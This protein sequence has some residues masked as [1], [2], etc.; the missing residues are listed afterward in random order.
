M[1][2]AAW[3][4]VLLAF[5]GCES[6][7]EAREGNARW[8]DVDAQMEAAAAAAKR[9]SASEVLPALRR[10]LDAVEDLLKE[11]WAALLA[12]EREGWS[13][14]K[15]N[16]Q[17]ETVKTGGGVETAGAIKGH[18]GGRRPSDGT[19]VHVNVNSSPAYLDAQ[20][21][22]YA[23]EAKL[24]GLRRSRTVE[25]ETRDGLLVVR[26]IYKL[27]AEALVIGEHTVLSVTVG[28]EDMAL[29]EEMLGMVD[30]DLFKRL[31]A[32]LGRSR[33]R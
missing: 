27:R 28:K 4:A 18:G 24:E 10:A 5:A 6:E 9:R 3:M 15:P 8:D 25:T 29:L 2:T 21:R 30:L 19:T 26:Q 33:A 13:F 20:R 32:S 16:V 14:F 7:E 17:V 11:E 22:I 1:R 12:F 31:D 23:D